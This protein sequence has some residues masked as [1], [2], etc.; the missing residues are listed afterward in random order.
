MSNSGST[1]IDAVNAAYPAMAQLYASDWYVMQSRNENFYV[2][3]GCAITASGTAGKVDM[4]AGVIFNGTSEYIVTAVTAASTTITSLAD[5]TNPKWVA[6]E[7]TTAGALNFNAG[8]AAANPEK[9]TPTTNRVVVA[10][11]YVPANATAVDAL[12]STANGNAKIIEAR[13]LVSERPARI[14]F[15]D[16]TTGSLTAGTNWATNGTTLTSILS[17]TYTVPANSLRVGDQLIIEWNGFYT[18]N[19]SASTL[20]MK[21]TIGA[22]TI[23]DYTSASLASAATNRKFDVRLTGAIIANGATTNYH[24]AGL[25]VMGPTGSLVTPAVPA[26]TQDGYNSAGNFD[27]TTTN[28]LDLQIKLGTASAGANV[29]TRAFT[30]MKFPYI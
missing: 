19:A 5:A 25:Y 15:S 8:T 7:L 1:L 11:L 14:I 9:P 28:A 6:C 13:Q 20:E 10:W 29:Q 17:S 4:S 23:L 22:I 24:V 3:S 27:N 21:L 26:E 12:T 18:N 2:L 16:T 30:I